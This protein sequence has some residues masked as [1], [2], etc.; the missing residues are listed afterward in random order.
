MILISPQ[1]ADKFTSYSS[2]L[3]EIDIQLNQLHKKKSTY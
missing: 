1:E 2:R 3:T